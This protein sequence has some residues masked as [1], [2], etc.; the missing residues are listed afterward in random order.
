MRRWAGCMSVSFSVFKPA[1]FVCQI[2]LK[3]ILRTALVQCGM[4]NCMV[5]MVL[6]AGIDLA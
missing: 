6:C 5:A 4:N 1:H 3:A 2:H